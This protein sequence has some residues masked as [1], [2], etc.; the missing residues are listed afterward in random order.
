MFDTCGSLIDTWRRALK[1]KLM[2][3]G[4]SVFYAIKE[5]VRQCEFEH[6]IVRSN[7]RVAHNESTHQAAMAWR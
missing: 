1:N 4:V 2:W 5:N 7:A 6:N 3:T